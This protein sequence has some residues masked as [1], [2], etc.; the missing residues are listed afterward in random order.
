MFY[1]TG[2]GFNSVCLSFVLGSSFISGSD[3]GK[4]SVTKPEE[5]DKNS[6]LPDGISFFCQKIFK[7]WPEMKKKN[8]QPKCNN[9]SQIKYG[10]D[11]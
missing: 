2:P 9:N 5:W 6:D 3:F 1:D 10:K 7:F 11:V 8:F 4:T